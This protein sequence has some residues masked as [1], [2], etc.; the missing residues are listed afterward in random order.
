MTSTM[1]FIQPFTE[2][3]TITIF[4]DIFMEKTERCALF[5]DGSNF[6][7]TAKLLNIDV[8]YLKL[9]HFFRSKTH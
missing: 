6:H 7:A 4:K 1:A 5:I 8:D 2:I 3:Y 9:L